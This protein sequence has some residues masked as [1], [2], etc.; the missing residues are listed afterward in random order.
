MDA[1]TTRMD[2]SGHDAQAAAATPPS[3]TQRVRGFSRSVAVSWGL[4]HMS[5]SVALATLSTQFLFFMTDYAGMA[6][7]TAGLILAVAKAS[8]IVSDL[9]VG[10]YS[11][12][13]DTRWGRRRPWI[14][15]GTLIAAM[16]LVLVFNL[17]AFPRDVAIGACFAGMLLF[18]FGYTCLH[19]PLVA[20]S[21]EIVSGYKDGG[22]LWGYGILFTMIGSN[23]LGTT[24]AASL[25]LWFGKDAHGYSMMSLVMAA[26]IVMAGTASVIGTARAPRVTSAV[27]RSAARVPVRAW[28]KSLIHNRSLMAYVASETI[29]YFAGSMLAVTMTYYLF[30]IVRLGQVGMMTYGMAGM[31][32]SFFGMALVL[33]LM[34]W[35]PKHVLAAIAAIGSGCVVLGL[36]ALNDRSGIV[37]FGMLVFVWGIFT[38]GRNLMSSA[39]VP[40]LIRAD[41]LRTGMRREGAIAS[42]TSSIQKTAPAAVTALFSFMLAYSGYIPGQVGGP[43]PQSAIDVILLMNCVIPGVLMILSS[44]ILLIFYDLSEKRLGDIADASTITE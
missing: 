34:K 43:Q 42:I 23:G 24:F 19:V 21:G 25:V 26:I 37:P 16:M 33:R 2:A 39:L 38:L 17:T 10:F 40:D 32:G 18:Y 15:A 27:S 30:N 9:A 12:R 3:I 29:C 31:I 22:A 44:L 13:I 41:Y 14:F 4:G 11:D 8:D 6:P 1:A 5:A 7:A 36:L 28:V 35:L 20:M